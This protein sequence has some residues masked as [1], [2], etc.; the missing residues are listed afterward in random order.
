LE[1]PKGTEIKAQLY[2]ENSD[3]VDIYP[4]VWEEVPSKAVPSVAVP[5]DSGQEVPLISE[6]LD[7]PD[8]EDYDC[9]RREPVLKL[10]ISSLQVHVGE[11]VQY[12]TAAFP[13]HRHR[14]EKH[15]S[16]F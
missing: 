16:P 10:D 15:E 8:P 13:V 11:A 9:E 5:A 4:W 12:Q 6:V 3:G 14:S 2:E 7:S 1:I